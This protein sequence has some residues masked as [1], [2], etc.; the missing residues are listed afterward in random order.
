MLEFLPVKQELETKE[1]KKNPLVLIERW[2][3]SMKQQKAHL[4]VLF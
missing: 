3:F 4:I 1:I 2:Q